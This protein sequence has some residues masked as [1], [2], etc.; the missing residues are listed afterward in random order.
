M[1]ITVSAKEANQHF[2]EVLGKAEA[3]ETV[4]ITKRGV[5]VATLEPYR[6]QASSESKIA[7]NQILARLEKGVPA[8]PGGWVWNRD[9]LY[10]S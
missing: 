5:P 6:P 9:E 2:A 4:V 7:W 3:G 8:P 1:S 10:E